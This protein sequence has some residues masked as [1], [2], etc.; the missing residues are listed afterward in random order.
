MCKLCMTECDEGPVT[1]YCLHLLDF[2]APICYKTHAC[3]NK[4]KNAV[5]TRGGHFLCRVVRDARL[6]LGYF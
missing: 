6:Y 1:C 5:L 3:D 4:S 2:K